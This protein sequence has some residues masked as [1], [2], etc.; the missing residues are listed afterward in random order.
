MTRVARHRLLLVV[1]LF[2]L[3]SDVA[4][5]GAAVLCVGPDDHRAVES[6]HSAEAGCESAGATAP[7][8][9]SLAGQSAASED[10]TDSPLHSEAELVSSA[11][12]DADLSPPLAA[13]VVTSGSSH[14]S[15]DAVRPRA[16][17]PSDTSA[18]RAHRTVVL[19][20]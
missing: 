2:H 6:E 9:P 19:L 15:N 14:E 5:A 16:R 7:A 10:C 8:A 12:P 3:L 11:Y 17:V 20:V 13:C 4:Y 18:L 1:A